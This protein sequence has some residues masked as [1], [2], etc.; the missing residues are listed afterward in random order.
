MNAR[1][2]PGRTVTSKVMAILSTFESGPSTRTL[3]Q[4]AE[5][6]DLPLPTAFRL[7][8][9]LVEWGALDKDESGTYLVGMR[10]WEVAQNA[11]R[12]L[13][14]TARPFLQ[15]L[16]SLTQ[17]TS[18]LA[19]RDGHEALYI[20]RIYSSK[21]VPRASRVGGRLPLHATAVG[22]VLLAFEEP[23]VREAY[24]ARD[25]ETPTQYTHVNKTRLVGELATIRQQG[26]A[27]T[28]EEVRAGSCSI[29]VPVL[30]TPEQ[31]GAAIGLVM[32][33]SQAQQMTRYLPPLRGIARR[34][35]PA[36]RRRPLTGTNL[37]SI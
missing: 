29:A 5:A 36:L 20:D 26:Y 18:H 33:S 28:S 22:K 2:S 11:G 17:E 1:Q 16:F 21:R 32:L 13:R 14:D 15:D 10:L 3:T 9:E 19:I 25:L 7:V 12:Q 8:N 31:A 30:L 37:T 34:I 23:W 6:A 27:T 4:I 35:A 24:I